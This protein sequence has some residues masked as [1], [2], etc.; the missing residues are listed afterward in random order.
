MGLLDGKI[1]VVTGGGRGVGRCHA[2]ALA[3]AGA[4]VVVSDVGDGAA[5]TVAEISA[6]GG[7]A[8]PFVGSVT[9][10]ES[11]EALV[12]TAIDTYGELDIVVNNAGFIRDA[13]LFAME[14]APFDAVAEVHLKGHFAVSR[15][16]CAHWRNVAKAAGEGAA[17]RPRRIIN[18]TSESGLFG[19]PG[20]INYGSAKG[21]IVSMT[22]IAAREMGRYNVTANCIAPR[23]RTP[24][25]EAI[26]KFAKPAEGFDKYDPANVSPT[27]VWLASDLAAG[28]SGQVF[29]VLGDQIHRMQPPTIAG[30]ITNDGRQWTALEI[31]DRAADLFGQDGSGV[32]PFGGPPM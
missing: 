9:S 12:Q 23:A 27:V 10:W 17:F 26:P 3:A 32:P 25:T 5:D 29:I 20:Q 11:A 14:E 13:P 16:A 2:E 28:V 19:G 15:F 31:A 7:Q 18:T 22:Y 30:V 24:M 8:S 4:A 6:R 1:A 21:G